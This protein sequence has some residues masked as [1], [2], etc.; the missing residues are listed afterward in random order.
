[1]R[2]LHTIVVA[3]VASAMAL[4]SRPALATENKTEASKTGKGITGGVL[5]GAEVVMLGEAAFKVKKPVMY[6][7]GGLIGGVGGG[8]G[9]YYIEK[10]SSD[11]KVPMYMLAGGMALIIPTTVAVLS[12][13]AY[14]PPADYTQDKGPSDEPVAEPAR[15]GAAPAPA[16]AAP[17][18]PGP[19]SKKATKRRH[20][21]A[22][23]EA[24][25]AL[26]APFVPPALVGAGSGSLS[27]SVPSVMVGSVYSRAELAQYGLKQATE[28]RVPVFNFVF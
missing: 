1:M 17:A 27:L 6:I 9:G 24:P 11:A 14:E 28:V 16:G 5:L 23:D 4:V 15:P 3:A 10:G 13:S 22:R 25:A 19:E 20:I 2:T 21:A 18:A 26:Y 8:V 12:A 7:V